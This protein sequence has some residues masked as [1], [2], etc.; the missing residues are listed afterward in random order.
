[1]FLNT[2]VQPWESPPVQLVLPP[3]TVEGDSSPSAGLL[4]PEEESPPPEPGFEPLLPACEES[5]ATI[6]GPVTGRAEECT[7]A[8][9]AGGPLPPESPLVPQPNM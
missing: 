3:S 2:A 9:A 1:M 5:A 6:A 4:N 8:A 7:D